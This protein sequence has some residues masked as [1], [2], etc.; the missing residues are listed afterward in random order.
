MQIEIR[1]HGR[2]LRCIQHDG[3]SFIEAPKTGAYSIRLRN[4]CARRRLAVI[5]VD[6]VNVING[7]DAGFEGSGYLLRAWET[8]E[9][10]GWRRDDNKVAAFKFDEQE[11]SYAAQTGRG[12]SNVGVIGVAVFDE[13]ITVTVAAPPL[14]LTPPLVLKEE[15]H[16]H[17][18]YPWSYTISPYLPP[19]TITTGG[20]LRSHDGEPVSHVYSATM[21]SMP[22]SASFDPI[23]DVDYS[24]GVSG[25]SISMDSSTTKSGTTRR[26]IKKKGIVDVGTGYGQEQT[27]RTVDVEF[28]R[29]TEV[30]AYVIELRYATRGRLA[31]WGVPVDQ[32]T[33]PTPEGPSAFPAAGSGAV[34]APPGWRG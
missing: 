29:A 2:T 24:R 12:T 13:K 28:E 31:S 15:H 17:H 34:P 14:V 6:G 5:S 11:E 30:P 9:I 23:G 1:Q 4:N 8:M 19:P 21:D 25:Q 27:F 26:R 16:H 32:K 22:A 7:E 10:P 33:K 3:K 18:H 20:I